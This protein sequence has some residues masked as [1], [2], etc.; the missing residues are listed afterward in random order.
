M[1][2]LSVRNTCMPGQCPVLRMQNCVPSWSAP[3]VRFMPGMRCCFPTS[4]SGHLFTTPRLGNDMV[5]ESFPPLL[6]SPACLSPSLPLP[7]T[8]VEANLISV[9]TSNPAGLLHLGMRRATACPQLTRDQVCA[10]EVSLLPLHSFQPGAWLSPLHVALQVDAS[11]PLHRPQEHCLSLSCTTNA[12]YFAHVLSCL[13][14]ESFP[15]LQLHLAR[16]ACL[17]ALGSLLHEQSS[18][19]PWSVLVARALP[20]ARLCR[21]HYGWGHSDSRNTVKVITKVEDCMVDVSRPPLQPLRAWLAPE[22]T[23]QSEGLPFR[24]RQPKIQCHMPT[25]TQ[26]ALHFEAA[27]S[28]LVDAPCPPLQSPPVHTACLPAKGPLAHDRQ[29]ATSSRVPFT[30]FLPGVR[31]SFSAYTTMLDASFPPV[32]SP[33]FCLCQSLPLSPAERH[34]ASLRTVIPVSSSQSASHQDFWLSRFCPSGVVVCLQKFTLQVPSSR[35]ASQHAEDETPAP[36]YN[37]PLWRRHP[38]AFSCREEGPCLHIKL[39]FGPF[40]HYDKYQ[41]SGLWLPSLGF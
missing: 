21:P 13:V 4:S 9:S 11:F 29:C 20:C 24:S 5:D 25:G 12:L 7:C 22:H 32:W 37:R 28:C 10:M 33:L 14:E 35:L 15:P 39:G 2:L 17:P 8:P 38:F 19:S 30:N 40:A 3:V 31:R 26:N 18:A 16:I 34:L 27:H 6:P 23:V 41:L 36:N 1:H